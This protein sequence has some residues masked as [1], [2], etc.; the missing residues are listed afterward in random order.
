MLVAISGGLIFGSMLFTLAGLR[1]MIPALLALWLSTTVFTVFRNYKNEVYI[2]L[3]MTLFVFFNFNL[4]SEYLKYF[5]METYLK[6]GNYQLQ[7][8]NRPRVNDFFQAEFVVEARELEPSFKQKIKEIF[9]PIRV[10]ATS[11]SSEGL[12]LGDIVRLEGLEQL[13]T[14]KL[15]GFRAKSLK[16]DKVFFE[17]KKADLLFVEHKSSWVYK[18]QEKIKNYYISTLGTY[19]GSIINSLLLGSRVSEIPRDFVEKVRN[20]GLGHF[21]AASGFHL[22][23]LTLFLAWL[24]NI[25]AV[26]AR[27]GNVVNVFAVIVYSA[28]AGFSPSIVRA[29]IFILAYLLLELAERKPRN[30]SLL[31]VI[32]GFT[33]LFDPYA[34]YDLGFQFSYLATLAIILWGP[35]FKQKFALLPD[36]LSDLLSVTLS[37]QVFLLPLVIYYFHGIQI[38][39]VLANVIFA[40]LLSLL[41]VLSFIG[42]FFL[43]KPILFVFKFV[44]DLTTYLPLIDFRI[45]IDLTTLVLLFLLINTL[46]FV[47]LINK[48]P[49]EDRNR[50]A[51]SLVNRAIADKWVRMSLV[52]CFAYLLLVTNIIPPNIKTITMKNGRVN[53]DKSIAFENGKA[54][55]HFD[56]K[57]FK[58][59]EIS[60]RSSLKLINKLEEVH[61][62]VL[63]NLNSKDIYLD[64]ILDIT[65]PQFIVTSVNK[66]SKRASEN[67][68][69]LSSYTHTILNS[70]KLYITDK[71][72]SISKGL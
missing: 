11:N 63:P 39:T 43:I 21:F 69:L 15:D 18:L 53:Y 44:L 61:L 13:K 59:L 1:L 55:K 71:Y 2:F 58:G 60:D 24:M 5:D 12:E 67:L 46:A 40:P 31:L 17:L 14:E 48:E 28:L 23:V 37:V 29:A 42:F 56:Y 62:L 35:Y 50:P 65:K 72:W 8:I 52:F 70:G 30:I 66:D 16:K 20:L 4:R 36:Y 51:W 57:G 7:I 54:V 41:V 19:D 22:L 9:L 34:I 10:F 3:L 38:W 68:K 25:F 47:F 64:T 45:D 27:A 33:L 26:S 49:I 6:Q 32:A